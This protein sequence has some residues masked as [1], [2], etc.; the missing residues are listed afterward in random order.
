FS[1]QQAHKMIPVRIQ[2]I[3]K[4][5]LTLSRATI[6]MN[7][8]IDHCLQPECGLTLAD[9]T[10]IHQIAMNL[11]TNAYHAVENSDGQI[12]VR[13][14][15]VVLDNNDTTDMSIEPGRYAMLSVEDNGTGIPPV[16]L[17]KIFDPYFTTKEQGKGTGLGLAVVYG[18]VKENK[19][20]I[21][22]SSTLGEGTVFKVYLPLMP[23]SRISSSVKG[24]VPLKGGVE[25][26]LLIDDELPIVKLEKQMLERLGYTVS[27]RTS[28]AD[29]LEAFKSHPD[30]YDL[31]ITDMSMPIMTGDQLAK[32]ILAVRPDMP[33][34]ICTGFSEKMN[35]AVAKSIGVKGLLMKP[36]EK[37]DMAQMAREV[38]DKANPSR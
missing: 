9:P 17:Q 4:E 35:A 32:E 22:V 24:E 2:H 8:K 21:R 1:R 36:I 28:S 18:I 13:V 16:H 6:P 15:E 37:S 3:L 29:A 23:V 38:L 25:R 20:D 11:I 33:I 34:I 19:G 7:I 14:Q 5:V 27:A 30:A 10:Q 12:S 26:I 31:V